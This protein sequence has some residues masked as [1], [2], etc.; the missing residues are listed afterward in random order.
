MRCDGAQ[1][2]P[3]TAA[4]AV[5]HPQGFHAKL[6]QDF[7]SCAT[8]LIASQELMPYPDGSRRPLVNVASQSAHQGVWRRKDGNRL[9]EVLGHL[10][11]VLTKCFEPSSLSQVV[12][13]LASK[14]Q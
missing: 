2:W 3:L 7:C 8:H 6:F 13:A 10:S 11:G 12:G 1:L 5:R 14:S 9:S 4:A